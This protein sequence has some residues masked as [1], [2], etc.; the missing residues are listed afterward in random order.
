MTAIGLIGL[1]ALG[2]G[3]FNMVIIEMYPAYETFYNSLIRLLYFSSGIYYTPISMPEWVRD[4]SS[5]TR[6]C[7]VSNFFELASTTNIIRTGWT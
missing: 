5:G 1:L 4:Y 7:K 6:Y 3:A 2:I